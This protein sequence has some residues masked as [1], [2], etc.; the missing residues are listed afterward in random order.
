MKQERS[1]YF[2]PNYHYK[3]AININIH[4]DKSTNFLQLLTMFF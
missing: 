2:P 1:I 3:S 4:I